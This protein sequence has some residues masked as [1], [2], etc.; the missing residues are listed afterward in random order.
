MRAEKIASPVTALQPLT[1]IIR[2]AG[3][4]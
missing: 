1:D 2:Y 4:P 3:S